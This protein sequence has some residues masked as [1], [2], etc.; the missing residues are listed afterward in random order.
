MEV[1]SAILSCKNRTPSDLGQSRNPCVQSRK[2]HS[3]YVFPCSEE[4]ETSSVKSKLRFYQR[5]LGG[6]GGGLLRP[7][8][9]VAYFVQNSAARSSGRSQTIAT[10]RVCMQ[11]SVTC[12]LIWDNIAVLVI[13]EACVFREIMFHSNVEKIEETL[14]QVKGTLVF[15]FRPVINSLMAQV[16]ARLSLDCAIPQNGRREATA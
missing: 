9:W 16:L 12:L 6:I 13:P 14:V 7:S 5:F 1:E 10:K 15:R 11:A 2:L 3:E 8:F 4:V